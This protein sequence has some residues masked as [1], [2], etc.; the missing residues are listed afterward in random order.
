M[1]QDYA[2]NHNLFYDIIIMLKTP[3][4]MISKW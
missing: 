3:K 1:D 2:R 4:A